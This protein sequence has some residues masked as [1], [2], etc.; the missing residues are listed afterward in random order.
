VANSFEALL[1]GLRFLTV[2]PACLSLMII[3]IIFIIRS[4]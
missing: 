1:V 2:Q 4:V 3:F